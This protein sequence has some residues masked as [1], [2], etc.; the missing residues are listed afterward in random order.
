MEIEPAGSSSRATPPPKLPPDITRSP[1]PR[2]D[3]RATLQNRQPIPASRAAGQGPGTWARRAWNALP[4]APQLTLQVPLLRREMDAVPSDYQKRNLIQPLDRHE[5]LLPAP[6]NITSASKLLHLCAAGGRRVPLELMTNDAASQL[7]QAAAAIAGRQGLDERELL[8]L[9]A[10]LIGAMPWLAQTPHAGAGVEL[11]AVAM[12][13]S[14]IAAH[15]TAAEI[16]QGIREID[17]DRVR[18]GLPQRAAS[19]VV[20]RCVELLM[21][22]ARSGSPGA[23]MA[24]SM[25]VAPHT[26]QLPDASALALMGGTRAEVEQTASALVA[27]AGEQVGEPRMKRLRA[28]VTRVFPRLASTRWGA[29]GTDLAALALAARGIE[30]GPEVEGIADA[31][32]SRDETAPDAQRA[33]ELLLLLARAGSA[34]VEIAASIADAETH[35]TEPFDA[36]LL[37][38][39]AAELVHIEHRP[40]QLDSL[41]E[42]LHVRLGAVT[43]GPTRQLSETDEQIVALAVCQACPDD[44]DLA[45]HA[46]RSLVGYDLRGA[47]AGRGTASGVDIAVQKTLRCLV[48]A[49]GDAVDA[50]RKLV[51]VNDALLE[52]A[53]LRIVCLAAK[54]LDPDQ[55]RSLQQVLAD[56]TRVH[57]AISQAAQ[58]VVASSSAAS[59]MDVDLEA[60][61]GGLDELDAQWPTFQELR[62]HDVTVAD[63]D[64]RIPAFALVAMSRKLDGQELT[65]AQR[66][67]SGAVRSGVVSESGPLEFAERQSKNLGRWLQPGA[68]ASWI[69]RWVF[70][71]R[72]A[73]DPVQPLVDNGPLGSLNNIAVPQL[74]LK[75]SLE[76]MIRLLALLKTP[77]DG[78]TPSADQWLA[79]HAVL[80]LLDHWSGKTQGMLGTE[81]ALL[82]EDLQAIGRAAAD[83]AGKTGEDAASFASAVRA[84]LDGEDVRLDQDTLRGIYNVV[85]RDAVERG[86]TTFDDAELHGIVDNLLKLDNAMLRATGS[87][88][89]YDTHY[90]NDD[91][92]PVFGRGAMERTR[93]NAARRDL[94]RAPALA[95]VMRQLGTSSGLNMSSYAGGSVP[96]FLT[97]V[98]MALRY[99]NVPG[100]GGRFGVNLAGPYQYSRVGES[101]LRMGVNA[102]GIE[103]NYGEGVT[104]SGAWS[105][106][107]GPGIGPFRMLDQWQRFSVMF[108]GGS[109]G[110]DSVYRSVFLRVPRIS[111]AEGGVPGAGSGSS[112]DS[113]RTEYLA[114]VIEELGRLLENGRSN[115]LL[116]LLA[117]F[118]A[119]SIGIADGDADFNEITRSEKSARVSLSQ[120]IVNAWRLPF[121]IG[122][123]IGRSYTPDRQLRIRTHGSTDASREQDFTQQK[124]QI[125]VG[126]QFA[127][128]ASPAAAGASMLPHKLN[129]PTSWTFMKTEIDG[130]I[131]LGGTYWSWETESLAEMLVHF[132]QHAQSYA[133][134]MLSFRPDLQRIREGKLQQFAADHTPQEVEKRGEKLYEDDVQKQLEVLH[135]TILAR[136]FVPGLS[137]RGTAEISVQA[138]RKANQLLAV[139]NLAKL[140]VRTQAL[141]LS[142]DRELRH[143]LAQASASY[144]HNDIGFRMNT[145]QKDEAGLGNFLFGGRWMNARTNSY[146]TK[147]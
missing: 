133:R 142:T 132:R 38:E 42:A 107:V 25:V 3:P 92:L 113:L 100:F 96:D 147:V 79:D 103:F 1:V 68:G 9:K 62:Q 102:S 89:D 17:F 80:A 75:E 108:E 64:W 35:D 141:A 53:D 32:A 135:G 109:G 121:A 139:L 61:R 131:H 28:E 130:V 72:L 33:G 111:E 30:P 145:Y 47:L 91:S 66:A 51:N 74:G 60:G 49:G 128:R 98:T 39:R 26:A 29:V 18:R 40:P 127:G 31:I 12:T 59:V 93:A 116:R 88:Q 117:K 15:C 138:H 94:N 43:L 99:A 125:G 23:D 118:P 45:L 101:I 70:G 50:A 137:Y 84:G 123:T 48:L 46:S 73:T 120:G 57:D 44:A 5:P 10:A 81:I 20:G 27:A 65:A 124:F 95:E 14:G 16:A 104:R 11:V 77:V 52:V 110:T 87:P 36:Q 140:S 8:T 63:A 115:V 122:G 67:A 136:P 37:R 19:P 78:K 106:G 69:N 54:T 97:L 58:A 4:R 119:L 71:N 76:P 55:T 144:V 105:L 129:F 6:L 41:Q 85:A 82:P 86:L 22:L 83:L 24:A 114:G 21:T 134:G 126:A 34:G 2:I 146:R 56:A 90:R 143:L 7:K 13:A 112:S